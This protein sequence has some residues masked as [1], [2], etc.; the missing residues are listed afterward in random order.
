ME[1]L[2]LNER[3]PKG[4]IR[5]PEVWLALQ[6]CIINARSLAGGNL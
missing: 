3:D 4:F 1:G 2:C 5:K 6:E